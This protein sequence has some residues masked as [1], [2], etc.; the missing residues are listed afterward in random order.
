MNL[1]ILTLTFYLQLLITR[2]STLPLPRS[3]KAKTLP[4]TKASF[5]RIPSGQNGI[6]I[7]YPALLYIRHTGKFVKVT[8]NEINAL[9]TKEDKHA[10]LLLTARGKL[11]WTKYGFQRGISIQGKYSKTF[12]CMNSTGRVSLKKIFNKQKCLF[13]MKIHKNGYYTFR[14]VSNEKRFL[15]FKQNGETKLGHKTE[16][17][18]KAAWMVMQI[19]HS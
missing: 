19:K 5:P 16:Y 18:H 2:V 14:L 17:H 4:T 1:I 6:N 8:S 9:T 13:Y 7:S 10:E 11:V 12:V 3:K 15:G